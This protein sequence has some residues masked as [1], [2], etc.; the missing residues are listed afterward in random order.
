MSNTPIVKDR[1]FPTWA[2]AL[3]HAN[4]LFDKDEITRAEID[5][6]ARAADA[7]ESDEGEKPA[8]TNLARLSPKQIERLQKLI[9]AEKVRRSREGKSDGPNPAFMT[10]G[11]FRRWASEEISKADRA[12]TKEQRT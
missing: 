10:D 12:K 6:I 1:T 11:E 5:K 8:G 9:A 3:D 2:A 4:E 7:E